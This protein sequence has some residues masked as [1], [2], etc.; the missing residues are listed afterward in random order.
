MKSEYVKCNLNCKS[1]AQ[2]IM[3]NIKYLAGIYYW[4]KNVNGKAY[5]ESAD[6]LPKRLSA[7]YYPIRLLNLDNLINRKIF[8]YGHSNFSPRLI[9][10]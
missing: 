6:N 4:Y 1:E 5:I 9:I 2:K 7:Y 3:S 8:K 10:L